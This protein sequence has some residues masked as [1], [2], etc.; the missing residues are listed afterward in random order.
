MLGLGN[1]F[2]VMFGSLA[3]GAGRYIF[4]A[5]ALMCISLWVYNK[6]AQSQKLLCKTASLEA[7]VASQQA[8][9]ARTHAQLT[10]AQTARTQAAARALQDAEELQK[11][12]EEA[13]AVKRS[14]SSGAGHC[15]INSND[16]KRLLRIGN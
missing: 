5:V 7:T 16:A 6:G 1:I 3:G 13:N 11:T 14:F 10:S 4:M 8:A 9:L 15:P 12:K 2:R